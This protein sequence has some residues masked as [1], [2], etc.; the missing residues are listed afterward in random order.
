MQ[1]YCNE[2]QI[3]QTSQHLSALCRDHITAPHVNLVPLAL[4]GD[5]YL[6]VAKHVWQ[7]IEEDLQGMPQKQRDYLNFIIDTLTAMKA[8][9]MAS[10][11]GSEERKALVANIMKYKLEN[12]DAIKDAATVFWARIVDNKERRKIC[13]R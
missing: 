6:Y 1:L 4:P 12:N 2:V 11:A 7:S 3:T 10:E 9:I 8:D 13:K 5:L